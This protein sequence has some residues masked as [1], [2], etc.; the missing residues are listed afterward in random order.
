MGV[1]WD[2]STFGKF[3]HLDAANITFS[4]IRFGQEEI[5]II[6]QKID[7][8]KI[9]DTF[10]QL[11][12]TDVSHWKDLMTLQGH[13]HYNKIYPFSKWVLSQ[14]AD[15][16]DGESAMALCMSRILIKYS[17]GDSVYFDFY[18]LEE[19]SST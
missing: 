4:A 7:I 1:Y 17:F 8:R 9:G 14:I 10:A 18:P 13:V 6:K 5:S 3:T 2:H 11:Y 12:H 19:K 15:T 16:K